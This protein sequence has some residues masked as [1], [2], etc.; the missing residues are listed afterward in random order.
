MGGELLSN[1]RS[2]AI[3]PSEIGLSHYSFFH[4]N[5]KTQKLQMAYGYEGISLALATQLLKVE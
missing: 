4:T 2:I 5:Y 3:L 1:L